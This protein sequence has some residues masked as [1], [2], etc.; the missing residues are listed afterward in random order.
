MI[1]THL[2]L[3]LEGRWYDVAKQEGGTALA[4]RGAALDGDVVVRPRDDTKGLWTVYLE[5]RRTGKSESLDEVVAFGGYQE[6]LETFWIK[7][8]GT[9]EIEARLMAAL[10][11]VLGH[12]WPEAYD[13]AGNLQPL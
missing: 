8:R 6:A 10:D 4:Y 7:A 13:R 3:R 9:P 5:L 2:T 1:D 12:G 11:E